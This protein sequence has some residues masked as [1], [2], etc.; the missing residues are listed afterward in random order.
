MIHTFLTYQTFCVSMDTFDLD[1]FLIRLHTIYFA[2]IEFCDFN[3][4]DLYF[5]SI[6]LQMYVVQV[7]YAIIRM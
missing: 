7:N 2:M 6:H 4:L 5:Q 1:Q 3:H